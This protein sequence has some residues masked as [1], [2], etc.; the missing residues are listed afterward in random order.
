MRKK[1]L[2]FYTLLVL[3]SG[4][5]GISEAQGSS[6]DY[7][8]G[9]PGRYIKSANPQESGL[10]VAA[11]KSA[12]DY[13]NQIT[14]SGISKW[15]TDWSSDGQWI[16]YN[17][18]GDIWIVSPDGSNPLNLTRYLSGYCY[19]PF[20]A[21]DNST[22]FFSR[23]NNIT[24]SYTIESVDLNGRNHQVIV[25]DAMAGCWSWNSRYLAYRNYST[26]DFYS[27]A[28]YGG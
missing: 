7:P 3:V 11:K 26:S 20:F 21:P 1:L 5:P 8:P 22:V 14:F 27:Y 13:G 23:E 15:E 10:Q 4:L 19:L 6:G 28:D 12:G 24:G 17:E 16:A 9:H 2:A 18:D 25:A